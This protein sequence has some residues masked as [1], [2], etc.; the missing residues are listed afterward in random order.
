[1]K[2][3]KIKMYDVANGS[4]VGLSIFVSGCHFHCP[5]C[6]NREAWDFNTGQQFDE[7]LLSDLLEKMDDRHIDHLSILGGEPL[8]EEN[9]DGI[10]HIIRDVRQKKPDKKIW[11][12]TGYEKKELKGKRKAVAESCDYIT[13]GRFVLSKRDISRKYS[14]SSNQQTETGNGKI[15]EKS[16][17]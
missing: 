3:A 10:A 16:Q 9:L 13:Y 12:W 6:F 1:M 2:I 7:K 4:G 17:N 8:S 11:L 5:G 14:G 15:V